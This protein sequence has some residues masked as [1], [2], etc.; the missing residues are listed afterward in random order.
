MAEM[1]N[2]TIAIVIAMAAVKDFFNVFGSMR[3]INVYICNFGAKNSKNRS[4]P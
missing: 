4:N 1:Q 3:A 2:I